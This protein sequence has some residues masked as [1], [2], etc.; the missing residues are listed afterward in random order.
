MIGDRP[1][2][3]QSSIRLP[4]LRPPLLVTAPGFGL[5]PQVLKEASIG[6]EVKISLAPEVVIHGRLLAP[7]GT[8][9]GGVRVPH[10]RVSQRH[11]T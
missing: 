11:E 8:P 10:Q 3:L 5:H 7:S 1:S 9:A 6:S 4:S 2:W